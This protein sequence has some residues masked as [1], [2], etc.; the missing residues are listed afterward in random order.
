M[1][2]QRQGQSIKMSSSTVTP[3]SSVLLYSLPLDNE[4]Q[5]QVDGAIR[6]S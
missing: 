1:F 2:I 4:L 5:S 3:P 6:V